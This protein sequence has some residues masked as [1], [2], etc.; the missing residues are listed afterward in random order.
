VERCMALLVH[1]RFVGPL[2][3][4]G[5]GHFLI[6]LATFR[7]DRTGN[8]DRPVQQVLSMSLYWP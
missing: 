6:C 7:L 4:K 3:N 8:V 5:F 1:R 2:E